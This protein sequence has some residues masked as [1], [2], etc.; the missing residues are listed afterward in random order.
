MRLHRPKDK[1]NIRESETKSII[2]ATLCSTIDSIM[3]FTLPSWDLSVVVHI[4]VM[5]SKPWMMLNGIVVQFSSNYF[6]LPMD[7]F[8]AL[9]RS[10]CVVYQQKLLRMSTA[11]E[12]T[13]Q[14]T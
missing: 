7:S 13:G 1:V 5:C 2:S 4:S 10:S 9:I 14:L 8:K 3:I 11:H 6:D 12:E